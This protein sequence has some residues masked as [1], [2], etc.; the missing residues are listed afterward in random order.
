MVKFNPNRHYGFWLPTVILLVAAIFYGYQYVLRVL[1][2]LM[3]T[4][5]FSVY[6]FNAESFGVIS[7]AFYLSYVPMQLVAGVLIDRF[8]PRLML[9]CAAI[10]CVLGSFMFTL[11]NYAALVF[12][13]RVF[14]G[15]GAAFAFIGL[16]KIALIWF[17]NRYFGLI[18]GIVTALGMVG[19][20]LGDV[21]LIAHMQTAVWRITC[22]WVGVIG[23]VIALLLFTFLD[24]VKPNPRANHVDRFFSVVIILMRNPQVWLCAF[25]AMLMSLPLSILAES[26]GIVYLKQIYNYSSV[27][28]GSMTSMLF[29]GWIIGAPFFGFLVD[30]AGHA[31][32]LITIGATISSIISA[33]ILYLPGAPYTMSYFLFFL[34]G[35]F[36]SVQIIMF[37]IAKK[38]A[39]KGYA[40]TAFG[41]VNMVTT[42]G[43][44]FSV[45][46]GLFLHDAS[47]NHILQGLGKLSLSHQNYEWAFLSIPIALVIAVFLS[48]YLEQD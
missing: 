27:H 21:S 15:F 41:F 30:R 9:T 24:D 8:G 14:I 23:I 34:F 44:F 29:L 10:V 35:F 3:S 33:S 4:E 26:W 42:F 32:S 11:A 31:R 38:H 40:A 39:P 25:I 43:G 2:S 46:V 6:H 12:L 20:L 48:I 16:L 45:F 19:A 37:I 36:S 22:F 5:L 47:A 7:A 13:A 17:P 28:A 18:A 1:P